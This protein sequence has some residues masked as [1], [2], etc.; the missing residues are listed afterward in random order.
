MVHQ[1]FMLVEPFTVLEN[2]VLGAEG[3]ALL[4]AGARQG[5]RRARAPGARLRARRRPR[6]H[7]RRPAGRAAAAGRDS[8]GAVPR[9]R[10]PDPRRADRRADAAG[11]RPPVPHPA[12]SSRTQGKTIILITHKLR[13]IMAITDRSRSC[14]GAR[15]WRPGRTAQD[16]ARRACRADGRAPGA[17]AGRQG[18]GQAR[19]DGPACR[20]SQPCATHQ[21]VRAHGRCH[22]HRARRRDRRHRRR[23]GQRPVASFSRSS[24]ASRKPSSGARHCSTACRHQRRSDPRCARRMSLAH[25]PE[26]RQRRGLV[27]SLRCLRD[28]RSSAITT[29]TPAAAAF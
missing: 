19:P 16:R 15:S 10:D 25:V 9:R 12:R 11:S 7:R 28:P 3:G 26:D 27:A 21:G 24:P 8:E 14:A 17:A 1:H 22:L 29:T 2:V 6:R 18:Q 4:G 5:A 23:I 20:E 13:E